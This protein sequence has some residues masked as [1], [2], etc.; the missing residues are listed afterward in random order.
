[1]TTANRV[2]FEARS[3]V[4]NQLSRILVAVDHSTPARAA[5]GQ[6][7]ALSQTH[8]AELMVVHAVPKKRPFRWRAR[9]RIELIA[10]LR[11]TAQA[12]GV[13]LSVS[14][15]HGDPT[16]VILLHARSRQPDLIVVGTHRR[17]GIDRLRVGSVAERIS[18]NA[19]RPVLIVPASRG[20]G[21]VKAFHHIAVAV[22]FSAASN[23]AIEQALALGDGMTPRVT[24][25]HVVPGHSAPGVPRHLY[26]HG[27][28]EYQNLLL[29]DAW[30]RL[31][32]AVP[33]DAPAAARIHA[34]VVAGDPSVEIARVAS[35][36]EA[37]LIV[38][39][40]TLRGAIS[41]TMFAPT[42]AR[43]MRRAERPL[44]VVPEVMSR[45][46]SPADTHAQPL[47]A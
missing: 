47:A 11:Q 44:L 25:L 7:L 15:Q 17:T 1:M 4:V 3:R 5:F 43:V 6:A 41:R 26:R 9:A 14:V 16:G 42:A 33:R 30:H 22:D 29:R 20:T 13:R 28:A 19:M 31:Q 45:A 35:E 2:Q 34:R 37:D 27:V 10:R 38:V 46:T 21:P 18:L 36:I 8:G 23:R 32:A 24:L 39:G 12:A 40:A